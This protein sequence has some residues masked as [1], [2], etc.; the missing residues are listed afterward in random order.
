MS[1]AR[2]TLVSPSLR[3]ALVAL[4]LASC[5]GG[6]AI[7]DPYANR[8]DPYR[9]VASGDREALRAV[10]NELQAGHHAAAEAGARKLTVRQPPLSMAH[11]LLGLSLAALGRKDEA[12]QA[13]GEALRIDPGNALARFDLGV[14]YAEQARHAEAAVQFRDAARIDPAY[15]DAWINVAVAE[16][17]LGRHRRAERAI[18]R[19]LALQP[20]NVQARN[21]RATL[22]LDQGMALDALSEFK[23][24]I[25]LAPNRPELHYNA[26]RAYELT[27]R[28]GDAA[29]S[30]RRFLEL[31]PAGDP[32]RAAAKAALERL[33]S[34]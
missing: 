20:D 26:A 16:A 31:A 19:A 10:W 25:E 9:Q 8:Y 29:A 24:L 6:C 15:V 30:Y 32:D 21:V 7:E 3:A 23:T 11:V 14:L 1:P 28:A 33:G 22:L 34:R 13:Y 27:E 2:A 4:L 18:G 12:E 5:A 17:E